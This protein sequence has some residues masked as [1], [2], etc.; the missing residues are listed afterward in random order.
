MSSIA[1]STSSTSS[2]ST[3]T[4]DQLLEKAAEF[5]EDCHYDIGAKFY[6]RALEMNP[7][8]TLIMDALADAYLQL[9]QVNEAV[10]L[11]EKSISLAPNSGATKWLSLAQLKLGQEAL[12]CYECGIKLLSANKESP[13]P[14]ILASAHCSVV[15]LHMT[16]LCDSE[17]AEQTCENHLAQALQLHPDGF[18]PNTMAASLRLVQQRRDEAIAHVDKVIASVNAAAPGNVA[19]LEFSLPL[20]FSAAKSMIEVGR[21]DAAAGVLEGVLYGDDGNPEVWCVLGVCYQQLQEYDLAKDYL[22]RCLQ[23]L[24]QDVNLMDQQNHVRGILNEVNQ[25]MAMRGNGND[26][27]DGSIESM[28]VDDDL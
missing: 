9:D 8:N 16:D 24:L 15:E 25:A 28:D 21:H 18:E 2:S 20:R 6:L 4:S 26:G 11:L 14:I 23:M 5:V 7:K 1:I 17:G 13:Q 27:G 12:E 22:E 19:R 3:F 10:L